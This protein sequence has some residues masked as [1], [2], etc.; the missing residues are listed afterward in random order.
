MRI[1]VIIPCYNV[2]STIGCQ[3][4]ALASQEWSEP[5]EVIVA[6]NGSSDNSVA[7]VKTFLERI[8]SLVIVLWLILILEVAPA[9]VL[10]VDAN[11]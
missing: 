11:Q 4:E 7:I 8:P 10:L 2:A 3:L 5:W 1:S 6:D 9:R